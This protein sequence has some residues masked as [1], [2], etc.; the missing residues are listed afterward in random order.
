MF[1]VT[2]IA[3]GLLWKRVRMVALDDMNG[4]QTLLSPVPHAINAYNCPYRFPKG[5][6]LT[7]KFTPW[8]RLAPGD[9]VDLATVLK[10]P[11]VQRQLFRAA[12]S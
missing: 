3:A 5:S 1:E 12:R 2:D 4:T 9:R 8:K 6:T 10:H 11:S 7:L